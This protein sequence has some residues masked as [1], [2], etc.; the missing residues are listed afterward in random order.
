MVTNPTWEM[1]ISSV[2]NQPTSAIAELT[3]IIKIRKYRKFH[4]G[5]HFIP[6]AM[7]VH[8]ALGHDVDCFIKEC[9][10]LFHDRQLKGH[11][12]LSF[13]IQFFKQR[14]SVTL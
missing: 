10:H 8:C 13:C 7:E 2:I 6:M 9:V 3:T 14:V 11:L 4:E 5:Y 1:V 12:S